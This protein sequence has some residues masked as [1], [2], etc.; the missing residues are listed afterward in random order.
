[1]GILRTVEGFDIGILIIL[2]KTQCI[3]DIYKALRSIVVF[4]IRSYQPE[5]VIH[6][7]LITQ[8]HLIEP[9]KPSVQFDTGLGFDHAIKDLGYFENTMRA[10]WSK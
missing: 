2:V 8:R 6:H 10:T 7:L 3:T 5:C 1:M 4:T 9:L